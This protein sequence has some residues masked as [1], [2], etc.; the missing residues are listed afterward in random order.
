MYM[1]LQIG[2][3]DD[4][5]DYF[6]ISHD[7]LTDKL[8]FVLHRLFVYINH[9][10]NLLNNLSNVLSEYRKVVFVGDFDL[11]LLAFCLEHLFCH[12]CQAIGMCEFGDYVS[13]SFFTNE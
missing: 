3:R 12:G 13:Y 4:I 1:K 5:M 9:I 11:F 2:T 6:P 8:I 10:W 7:E